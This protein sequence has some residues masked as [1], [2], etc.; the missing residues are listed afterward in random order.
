MTWTKLSDDFSDDCS[1]L[2]DAAFRCHVEGLLR[3]MRRETGGAFTERDLRHLDSP[4]AERGVAEL[5]AAGMWERTP[6]GY[7]VVHHMEHQPEPEVIARRREPAADRQR[8]K[9]MKA[10]GIDPDTGEDVSRRDDPRD[11]PRDDPRYPGRVGSGRDGGEL[12]LALGED[13]KTG[14]GG[15]GGEPRARRS[16][17]SAR[18]TAT[19][20]TCPE[21]GHEHGGWPC[22]VCAADAKAAD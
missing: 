2:S 17:G 16:R 22:R 1:E 19:G 18:I 11:Y 21:Y 5:V 8:R 13:Q 6:T 20:R 10:V 9:R 15:V 12:S 14:E 3:V 4:D 7:R